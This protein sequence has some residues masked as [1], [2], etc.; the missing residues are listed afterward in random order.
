MKGVNL[1]DTFLISE[2]FIMLQINI[3]LVSE[4]LSDNRKSKI[5]ITQ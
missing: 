2:D 4:F 3:F 5:Y 1:V